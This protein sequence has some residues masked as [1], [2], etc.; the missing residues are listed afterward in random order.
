MTTNRISDFMD[1]E[2]LLPTPLQVERLIE[3]LE[4]GHVSIADLIKQTLTVRQSNTPD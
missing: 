2:T 4:S 1:S 3:L